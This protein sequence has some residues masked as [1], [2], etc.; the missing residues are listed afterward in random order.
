[1]VDW[2]RTKLRDFLKHEKCQ[3]TEACEA[4]AGFEF[5]VDQSRVGELMKLWMN[6]HM[7]SNLSFQST[8]NF[9]DVAIENG[10]PP[11]W[12]SHAIEHGLYTP[13]KITNKSIQVTTSET[14]N[15]SDL[16]E[17]FDPVPLSVLK[18]LFPKAGNWESHA[19]R[20]SRNGLKA[21]RVKRAMFNPY[22]AARWLVS[23]K[24][25][26]YDWAWCKRILKKQLPDR[27]LDSAHLLNVDEKDGL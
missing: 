6:H 4:L 26:E 25:C 27:S 9:I 11:P 16:S 5:P 17:L 13:K 14:N 21:A 24:K 18:T 19:E 10:L 15:P 3:M 7:L 2:D 20:A 12:L 22:K 1:M 8:R 23:Q